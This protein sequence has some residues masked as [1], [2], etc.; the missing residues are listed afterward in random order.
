MIVLLWKSGWFMWLL[1]PFASVG[2]MAF[3]NYLMQ[4]VICTLIFYGYGLGYFGRVEPY[5]LWY[6]VW[7]FGHLRLCSM[8]S[9][10]NIFD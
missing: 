6:F 9:G 5:E 10:C 1:K 2:Q 8:S 3:T 4:S 7:A